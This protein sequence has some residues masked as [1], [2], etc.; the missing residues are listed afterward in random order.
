MLVY[1]PHLG[2]RNSGDRSSGTLEDSGQSLNALDALAHRLIQLGDEEA[3]IRV[4]INQYADSC[5]L[6]DSI[7]VTLCLLVIWNIIVLGTCWQTVDGLIRREVSG[8]RKPSHSAE[9]RLYV[10]TIDRE[11]S[12]QEVHFQDILIQLTD[13]LRLRNYPLTGDGELGGCLGSL[14]PPPLPR[15]RY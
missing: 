11:E 7:V 13:R 5:M 6:A 9:N 1:S 15:R 3:D 14:L 4:C 12:L 2:S 10:M 8:N